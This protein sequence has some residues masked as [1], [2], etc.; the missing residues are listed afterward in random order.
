MIEEGT[1]FS[2]IGLCAFHLTAFPVEEVDVPIGSK[3]LGYCGVEV[4]G[5]TQCKLCAECTHRVRMGEMFL[6]PDMVT[7][8]NKTGEP[9]R[10]GS[11]LSI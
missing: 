11:R 5:S 7:F 3:S 9:I 6:R 1:A 10:S 4:T 8:I 2:R